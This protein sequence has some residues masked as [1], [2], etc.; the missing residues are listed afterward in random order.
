[1]GSQV[2][3]R[4]KPAGPGRRL[5]PSAGTGS[6]LHSV[7]TARARAPHPGRGRGLRAGVR[8]RPQPRQTL[9]L[10]ELEWPAVPVW[11]PASQYPVCLATGTSAQQLDASFST[12]GALQVFEVDL[13]EPSLDLK[14]GD[15][16]ASSRF[17]KLSWGSFGSGLLEGSGVTAN[18]GDNGVLTPYV[19]HIRSSGKEPV[20][21]Q[22]QKHTGARALDFNPSQGNLLAS[23]ANG[24][25]IFIWD[26]S[27]LSVPVTLGSKLQTLSRALSWNWRVQRLLSSAHPSGTAVVWDL[28]R[29]EP[30]I[31][32]SDRQNKMHCSGL[33]W[34]PGVAPRLELCSEDGSVLVILWDL[35]F[36]S[37]PLKVLDSHSRGILSVSWNQADAELLL[38]SAKDEQILCWNLGSSEVVYKLPTQSSWCFD[39]QW[40]PGDPLVF[41]AAS[42]DGWISL[43]S[44]MGWSWENQHMR[45]TD[46]MPEQVAQ[47]SWLPPLRNITDMPGTRMEQEG[48][49]A[50]TSEARLCCACSG[51]V[52]QLVEGWERCPQASSPV[53]LRDLMEKVTVLNR[54]LVFL[55]GSGRVSPGPTTTYRLTQYAN[56]LASQG[57]LAT[58]MSFLPS[59]CAQV[60]QLRNRLFHTQGSGVMGQPS[61]FSFSRVVVGAAPCPEETSPY[62]S[63]SLPSHHPRQSSGAQTIGGTVAPGPQAGLALSVGPGARP[64]SLISQANDLG[65]F[66]LENSREDCG[67]SAQGVTFCPLPSTSLPISSFSTRRQRRLCLRPQFLLQLGTA[68]LSHLRPSSAAPVSSVSH[69]PPGAPGGLSLRP[70]HL[71]PKKMERKELLPEHQSWKAS[72]QALL[73]RCSLPAA[74]LKT[75]RKLDEAVQRLE[76]LYEKLCGGW[77][78]PPLLSPHIMAGLHEV[79]RCVDAGSFAQGLEVHAQV[80]GCS[81]FSEVSGF[82]PVLKAVLLIAYKLQG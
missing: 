25:E 40:C 73:Q 7:P 81:S 47:A 33:A 29:N 1:M 43:Y 76:G 3:V 12:N 58:A 30:I 42:F 41:S 22:R 9:K 15:L 34:H 45:Q 26:L 23:G 66:G 50:L 5:P 82:M 68:S 46:K 79:A 13:R 16:P 19:T 27:N 60:Q 54:S 59:D 69:A 14:H 72:F 24:S 39:V 78:V 38:S 48:G 49:R 17:H 71:P 4:A 10:K 52:E 2:R 62:R 74:G 6:Q 65:P 61:P 57:S 36:A 21:A 28:R 44:V 56:F 64:E 53:A 63:G 70:Q 18:G 20:I 75:T 35:H 80:V 8:P 77:S 11:S 67:R 31:K 51:N 37:S 55:Q 32:V